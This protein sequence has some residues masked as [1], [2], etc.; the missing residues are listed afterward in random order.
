M[1]SQKEIL[2]I[3][4]EKAQKSGATS[5]AIISA[6][7]I[8][9]DQKFADMCREPRCHNYGLSKSCPPNVS[10]PSGFKEKLKEFSRALF[11]KIDIPSEILLSNERREVFQLLHEIAA[12][13]EQEAVK[14]GFNKAQAYAGGSCKEIFCHDHYDCE[15]ISKKGKCRN[16]LSARQSMS[17]FGINVSKLV[18]TA[19]WEDD[20][21]FD[22]K[23][24]STS[25]TANVYGLVLIY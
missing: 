22:N 3:L 2:K 21:L 10:G 19:G 18:E 9:I 4:T 13:I 20:L 7:S 8:L 23:G 6:E 12:G 5:A 25:D 17:G 11:F 1:Q 15:V 14:E 24:N 16:P